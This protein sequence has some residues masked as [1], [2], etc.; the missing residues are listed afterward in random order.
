MRRLVIAIALCFAL[1]LPLG[2]RESLISKARELLEELEESVDRS[3]FTSLLRRAE[4]VAIFPEVKRVG[5]FLGGYFGK[6]LVLREDEN[7]RFFGPAFFKIEG[8]SVGPQVGIQVQGLVL[9][10]MNRE[11]IETFYKDGFT[12]GGNISIAAGPLGRGFSAG[13]DTE[14]SSSIYAY[15]IA[16]GFFAGIS[17]E[18]ARIRDNKKANEAF[19]GRKISVQEILTGKQAEDSATRELI[20]T[21]RRLRLGKGEET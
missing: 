19:F 20:R 8:L 17:I 2:A 18:G 10:L 5:L 3:L 1:S 7:G 6:G 16:R 21:I 11:G 4:G 9:L 12:L 13:V 14:L 15:A